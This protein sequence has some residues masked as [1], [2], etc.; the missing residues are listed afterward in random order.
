M[1]GQI[2]DLG[3]TDFSGTE[4]SVIPL[5]YFRDPSPLY[6]VAILLLFHSYFK[7]SEERKFADI[8]ARIFG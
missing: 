3:R 2:K 7:Y 6:E 5:L 1:V 4:I 8:S